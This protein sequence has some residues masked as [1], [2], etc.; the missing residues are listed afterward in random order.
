MIDIEVIFLLIGHNTWEFSEQPS[1]LTTG[2]VG[3][4]FEANG[5]I[6]QDFDILHEDI[7]LKQSS[8]ERAQQ[9]MLEEAAQIA[10]DKAQLNKGQIQFFIG[11]DLINQITP[12]TFAAKTIGLPYLGLFSACATSV[13]SLALSAAIINNNGANHILSGT[14]SHNSAAERQFRYP[15]E[16]GGQKPPTAQW[17]VTGAGCALIGKQA[18]GPAITSATIGKVVDMGLTD[19]FNMGGAMAPAAVDT[20]IRHLQDRKIDASYY[21]LIIT[22]D[23]GQIGHDSSFELLQEKDIQI[24]KEQYVDCG[25]II[26]NEDQPV[27]SGGS[28]T[29]CSA[30]VT[31]GHIL[32]RMQN[33]ELDK[34]LFV[35]TGSLHSPMSV[36]QKNTIPCIAHAVSIE[37]K[38]AENK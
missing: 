11:G 5:K 28:G 4:P 29:A 7:W 12:T 3:G 20:I 14:A 18:T 1:I 6:A 27:N 23:L 9:I 22:G 31:Y 21:D 15:T 38:E 36:Q 37:W 16:Y 32:K 35:A 30:V 13:E 19:P 26:Y 2:V 8:F 34:V 33:R 25:L 24:N 17:T 10:M